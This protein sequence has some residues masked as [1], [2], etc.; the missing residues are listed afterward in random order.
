MHTP[1]ISITRKV[2]NNSQILNNFEQ[3]MDIK[4]KFIQNCCIGTNLKRQDCTDHMHSEIPLK[5]KFPNSISKY[6]SWHRMIWAPEMKQNELEVTNLV[7][8]QGNWPEETCCE[9]THSHQM[10]WKM[11]NLKK[12]T[13]WAH[14]LLCNSKQIYIMGSIMH[15]ANSLTFTQYVKKYAHKTQN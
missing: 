2:S 7:I 8:Q 3:T 14:L 10:K 6:Y 15:N 9:L 4:E 12:V 13:H 11:A 1:K 5:Y